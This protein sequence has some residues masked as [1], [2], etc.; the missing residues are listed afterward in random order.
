MALRLDVQEQNQ[1][2]RNRIAKYARAF[3]LQ[4]MDFPWLLTELHARNLDPL[5]GILADLKETLEQD[6]SFL[7]GHWVSADRRFFRFEGTLHR[8][9]RSIFSL[10]L[11]EQVAP[12]VSEHERGTGKTFAFLALEVLAEIDSWPNKSLERTREG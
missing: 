11:W 2:D 8:G 6:G 12:V 3:R 7:S 5:T 10:E 9:T 4:P 1:A